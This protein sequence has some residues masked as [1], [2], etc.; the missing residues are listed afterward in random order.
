M[1]LFAQVVVSA[2]ELE[3]VPLVVWCGPRQRLDR[4][5]ETTLANA[6]P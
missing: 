1:S 6:T 5:R 4:Q 3:A 2:T